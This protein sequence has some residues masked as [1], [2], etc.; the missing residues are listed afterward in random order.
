[1]RA[2]VVSLYTLNYR[3]APALGT[4]LMG[5]LSALLGLQ[6]PVVLGACLCAV[7]ALWLMR[8]RHELRDMLEAGDGDSQPGPAAEAKPSAAQ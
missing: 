1:M 6:M 7:A 4:L 8:R 2:R 5:G 3:A